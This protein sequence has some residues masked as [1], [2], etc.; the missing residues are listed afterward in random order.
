[1]LERFG[2]FFKKRSLLSLQVFVD[3]IISLEGEIATLSDVTLF[4]ESMAR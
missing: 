1:M 4:D 2:K 3:E